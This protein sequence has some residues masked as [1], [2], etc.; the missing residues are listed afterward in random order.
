MKT[1]VARRQSGTGVA[2]GAATPTSQYVWAVARIAMGWIFLWA[3]VDKL[4]GFGFATPAGKGWLEGGEPTRGFLTGSAAGPFEDFYRAIAGAGWADT[5]FMLGLL[6]LGVA[7]L[8]GVG[9]QIAA[10]TGAVLMT[11]MWSV[12][13]P[14]TTN[15]LIDDHLI[16]AVLLIGL[17]TVNAGDTWGLGRRWSQLELVRRY[18][19]LR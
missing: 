14:A 11:L 19:V 6:G 10:G 1:T 17:A 4:F 12:T 15:P 13:L 8:A 5:L 9:M 2:E 3:F 18:P 7:L 16:L